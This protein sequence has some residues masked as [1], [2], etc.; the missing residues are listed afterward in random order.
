MTEPAP[1][2]SMIVRLVDMRSG[3]MV[4]LISPDG[5]RKWMRAVACFGG[6]AKFARLW[7]TDGAT[8]HAVHVSSPHHHRVRILRQ[9]AAQ[10]MAPATQD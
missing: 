8:A 7:V 3:D 4:A 2:L 9:V 1:V 5:Q 6:V 10:D